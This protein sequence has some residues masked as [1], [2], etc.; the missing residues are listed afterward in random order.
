MPS[1][2]ERTRQMEKV[3]T[4][5]RTLGYA[6]SPLLS[7]LSSSDSPGKRLAAITILQV[8]PNPQMFEWLA[9]RLGI[10]KPFLGYHAA[11]AL[12]TAARVH[13]EDQT[14]QLRNAIEKA[15]NRLGDRRRGT[16]RD[17]VL[18]DALRELDE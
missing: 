15:K 5:M 3:A 6:A 16:D 17:R 11:V 8:Q 9:D 18:N 4:K 13:D 2:D 7:E 1:G 14:D 12:L 10:E